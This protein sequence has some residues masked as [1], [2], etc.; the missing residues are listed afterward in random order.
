MV[1]GERRQISIRIE[2]LFDS[3]SASL[4]SGVLEDK[5]S[6]HFKDL[7]AF[8]KTVNANT[9]NWNYM[10]YLTENTDAFREM[11]ERRLMAIFETLVSAQKLDSLDVPN[12]LLSGSCRFRDNPTTWHALA[13]NA[14]G[15]F[16]RILKRGLYDIHL[17]YKRLFY[18]GCLKLAQLQLKAPSP[19]SASGKFREY[20]NFLDLELNTISVLLL[21]AA[22]KAFSSQAGAIP[23]FSK[24]TRGNKTDPQPI[25]DSNIKKRLVNWTNDEGL[26][27]RV[28]S[29]ERHLERTNHNTSQN[30]DWIL[31][32]IS[33]LE[34]QIAK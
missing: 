17:N 7:R 9:L 32:I 5:T 1:A 13:Q 6:L 11:D 22:W 15:E 34:E 3:S 30:T 26:I 28:F 14:L 21:S 12:F 4:L 19:K 10:L 24:I 33:K 31:P 27:D 18:A 8:L 2:V 23:F 16:D 20:L 25:Y 29:L